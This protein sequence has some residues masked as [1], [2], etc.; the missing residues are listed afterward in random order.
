[1]ASAL[2][3][4]QV[5]LEW[6]QAEIEGLENRPR[7]TRD[8]RQA[9]QRARRRSL[10][11]SRSLVGLHKTLAQLAERRT[12]PAASNLPR[13]QALLSQEPGSAPRAAP[14]PAQA[15]TGHE[16]DAVT[17]AALTELE[18]SLGIRP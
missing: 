4:D 16:I 15:A 11:L 5:E 8:V 1:V 6:A 12:G 9:L 7:K 13:L 14:E 17:E 10:A 18:R 3:A 2:A